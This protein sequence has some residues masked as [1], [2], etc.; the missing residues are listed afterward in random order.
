MA[1]GPRVEE[2]H[3]NARAASDGSGENSSQ[4]VRRDNLKLRVGPIARAFVSAPPP[5]LRHMTEASALHMLVRDLDYQFGPER[6]PRKILAVT[7]TAL[8]SR[9]PMRRVI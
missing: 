9:H 2:E 4:L 6:R 3:L 5:E 1:Q 7:P 8:A